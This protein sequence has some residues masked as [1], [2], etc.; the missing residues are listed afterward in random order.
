[1]SKLLLIL[2]FLF[3]GC[4]NERGTAKASPQPEPDHMILTHQ[5]GNGWYWLREYRDDEHHVTCYAIFHGEGPAMSCL[6]D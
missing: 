1:M 4:D 6:R 2:P 5:Q 3:L